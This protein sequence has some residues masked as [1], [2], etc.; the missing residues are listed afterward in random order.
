MFTLFIPIKIAPHCIN[1]RFLRFKYFF[2][3]IFFSFFL[4]GNLLTYMSE[5][6]DNKAFFKKYSEI[7]R[8]Q[9]GLQGASE[10]HELKTM[11]P[12]FHGKRV[13]DLGCGYGWHCKYASE[14]GA[15]SVTGVDISNNMIEVARKRNNG[16]NIEYHVK[17]MQDV[18]YPA[19]SFDAVISSLAIHYLESFDVV[20]KVVKRCLV[21]GGDF[22]FSVEHP[23]FTANGTAD[24]H[25]DEE[26]NPMHWPIDHYFDEGARG[27]N[28]LGEKVR[29]YHR[30]VGTYIS[31][32]IQNG[33][34]IT[35]VCEPV[36]DQD[37][38]GKDLQEEQRRPMMLM[39]SAKKVV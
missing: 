38:L 2:K 13:L 39:I 27:A 28:F 14:N 19:D 15:K 35:R 12:D 29:K 30:T 37:I 6:D 3:N 32:L 16:P 8:S 36:P 4:S 1:P 7:K 17:R 18:D 24:W 33:F 5:Y 31:T 10:W 23:I 21:K 11:L 22:V 25:Y 9:E 20:C 34:N 26:G